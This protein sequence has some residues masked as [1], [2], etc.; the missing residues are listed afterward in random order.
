MEPKFK[1]SARQLLPHAILLLAIGLACTCNGL[2]L[3]TTPASPPA[4]QP[5]N[6]ATEPPPILP[7]TE[8]PP[9]APTA[10]QAGL[11]GAA[12]WMIIGT[13]QG[14][15]AANT[16]G[17]GMSQLLKG[18]LWQSDFSRSIQPKGNLVV[19]ITSETDQ[20]HHLALNLLSF[21]DGSMQKITDL[22]NAQTEPAV[23]A[24]PGTDAM[25]AMRAIAEHTSYCWS[26]D[27][28]RLA[29][30]SA[31]DG[32]SA[33]VYIYDLNSKSIKRVSNDPAQDYAPS[34]SSDGNHLLYLS[35]L[36]FGTG[37]GYVMDGV[38]QADGAGSNV[39]LLYKSKS[40]GEDILGWRDANTAILA[41]W[42]ISYGP[43]NLRLYNVTT[44]QVTPIQDGTAH[45]AVADIGNIFPS[46][47]PGALLFGTG[48][49]LSL[50]ASNQTSPAKL[51]GSAVDSVTWDRESSIFFVRFQ[52]GSL[53][54]YSADGSQVEKAP[55]AL[56]SGGYPTINV[57]MYGAIWG[58]TVNGG[59]TQGAWIS[60][61]GLDIPQLTDKPAIAPL[62][63]PHN[64]LTFFSDGSLYRV[65]FDGH[66]AD[67]GQVADISGDVQAAA[68]VGA[69]G[70]DIY[71]P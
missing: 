60:G 25:E 20:Y 33:D 45:G 41:T 63:D 15:W 69:K 5:V 51:S 30:I 22:S 57:S 36:G 28:G 48:E 52:D 61:P 35:A 44:K 39:N 46:I 4:T 21:P 62:W 2:S 29:F 70:F 6:P 66:Y 9:A 37:A 38:W 26:P 42:N 14:I 55:A 27:G 43:G 54:T 17:S 11:S 32:P 58:W 67:L 50:L 49:G 23:D 56:S 12:P 47:D 7:A 71:T 40:G 65:T 68:W 31:Q 8:A 64:N 1:K 3:V 53:A 18:G 59:D 24:M 10:S 34:W 16:D 13:S 19:V